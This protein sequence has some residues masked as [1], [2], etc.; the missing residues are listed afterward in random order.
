MIVRILT[1]FTCAGLLVAGPVSAQQPGQMPRDSM[2]H[3][4]PAAAGGGMGMGSRSMMPDS[5]QARLDS[6]VEAMNRATGNKKVPAMA[7]VINQLVVERRA[8]HERMRAMHE[9]MGEMTG[10]KAGGP[11]GDSART[12]PAP[13]DTAGH[14]GCQSR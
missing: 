11:Q 8:M 3:G 12:L 9:H 6:L 2:H 14:A 5:A 10:P 13:G 7:A 4:M 1:A